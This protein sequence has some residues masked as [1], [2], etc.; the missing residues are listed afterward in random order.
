ME[1]F[2]LRA[3]GF[4][5]SFWVKC[6]SFLLLIALLSLA[7]WQGCRLMASDVSV[8]DA[9]AADFWETDKFS[10]L[11]FHI[12]LQLNTL[13]E[14]HM[15]EE[16]IRDL[17]IGPLAAEMTATELEL[18]LE[19][20]QDR[21]MIW[22]YG[23]LYL[24]AEPDAP[25]ETIEDVAEDETNGAPLLTEQVETATDG[26]NAPRLCYNDN[27][28]YQRVA[29]AEYAALYADLEGH[30]SA[31]MAEIRQTKITDYVNDLSQLKATPGLLYYLADGTWSY[32]NC[33]ND[34]PEYFE[35]FP[36]YWTSNSDGANGLHAIAPTLNAGDKIYVAFTEEF[37]AVAG[38]DW[39]ARRTE[40]QQRLM[41]LGLIGLGALLCLLHLTLTAGRRPGSTEAHLSYVDRVFLEVGLAGLLLAGV[42][43]AVILRHLTPPS[44]FE[45]VLQGGLTASTALGVLWYLSLVRRLKNGTA[46]RHTLIGSLLRFVWRGLSRL[47]REVGA[48][49]RETGAAWPTLARLALP[50]GALLLVTLVLTAA[51]FYQSDFELI[52][53]TLLVLGLFGFLLVRFA[54]RLDKIQKGLTRIRAGDYKGG[55]ITLKGGG[56][57]GSL[58]DSVNSVREGLWRAVASETRSE[59]M[60]TELITNVSHDLRTPLTSLINYVDLLAAEPDGESARQYVAVISEKARRLKTLTDDL[61]DASK[62]ASG[63]MR[64]NIAVV[65][66]R[67]VLRQG[68]GEL[69]DRIR[70]AGL[71]FRLRLG[72][73]NLH[74]AADGKLLWRALEN[75]LCNALLYALPGSRVYVDAEE[76]GDG[77][78]TTIRNISA[79]ELSKSAEELT[80]RFTRGDESRHGEGSGLGLAITKSLVELMN[81][82]LTIVVDGDLFKAAVWMPGAAEE[83]AASEA[84][85]AMTGEPESAV[86]AEDSAIETALKKGNDF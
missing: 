7:V 35:S 80:T 39:E 37:P 4:G 65:D 18:R 34:S 59:R 63:A 16:F 48:L 82:R 76:N 69:D 2:R 79:A 57:T 8:R 3:Q 36:A 58:A 23:A 55:A 33:E 30:V 19:Y 60:K 50:A 14:A 9:F 26:A 40:T 86:T 43:L 56:V 31:R 81:G 28:L 68:L 47:L 10:A 45:Q 53:L 46:W 44:R 51:A 77:V 29:G 64:A 74:V 15:S 21:G 5:R 61:F 52:F 72:E 71:D 70:A 24:P 54:L 38:S 84:N 22:R 75:L 13:K 62:A 78:L 83:N 1:K 12:A 73:G 20:A 25:G 6:L 49:L 42:L 41:W 32:S 17:E 67:A 27:L 66:M 85:R 11:S